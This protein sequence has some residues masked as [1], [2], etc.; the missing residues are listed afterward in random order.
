MIIFIQEHKNPFVKFTFPH[1]FSSNW[2]NLFANCDPS[3]K[4]ISGCVNKDNTAARGIRNVSVSVKNTVPIVKGMPHCSGS[5]NK[6]A[7]SKT[8]YDCGPLYAL[9]RSF[10][11]CAIKVKRKGPSGQLRKLRIQISGT[12]SQSKLCLLMR[13]MASAPSAQFYAI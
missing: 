1:I 8:F 9:S 4:W 12:Q 5:C 7:A 2:V 6:V 13:L 11:S 3:S 10:P